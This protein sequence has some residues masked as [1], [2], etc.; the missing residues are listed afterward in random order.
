M[1]VHCCTELSTGSL[2]QCV[3]PLGGVCPSPCAV[4]SL[5]GA[6]R[7]CTCRPTKHTVCNTTILGTTAKMLRQKRLNKTFHIYILL[8]PAVIPTAS[9]SCCV[10]PSMPQTLLCPS[11]FG[12]AWHYR[13]DTNG[14]LLLGSFRGVWGK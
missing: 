9:N 12:I 1:S 13:L 2:P 14:W 6:L 10:H 3:G 7:L 5:F 8:C 4:G 11:F